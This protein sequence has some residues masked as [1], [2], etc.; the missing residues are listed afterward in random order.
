MSTVGRLVAKEIQEEKLVECTT[1][2]IRQ[3][4]SQKDLKGLV[5][6]G[7]YH[8]AN[9]NETQTERIWGWLAE[10]PFHVLVPQS[11]TG[12]IRQ[13]NRIKTDLSIK[14]SIHYSADLL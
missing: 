5:T 4:G 8:A 7:V 3:S 1:P 6:G 9:T 14:Y 13:T 11:E 2:H 12:L 10:L